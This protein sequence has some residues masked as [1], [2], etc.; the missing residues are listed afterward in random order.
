MK[1]RIVIVD[2]HKIVIEGLRTIIEREP[3]LE[4]VGEAVTGARGMRLIARHQPDVALVDIRLGDVSGLEVCRAAR[5]SSP[6][7]RVIILTGYI[8]GDLIHQ[9][10]QAGAVGYLL[11]DAESMDLVAKIRQVLRGE[12]AFD[13]RVTHNL[14]NYAIEHPPSESDPLLSAREVE[15]LRLMAQGMTNAEIAEAL[16]LSPATIK[17]YVRNIMTKLEARNRVDAVTRAVRKGLI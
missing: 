17:D 11:K 9:A 7:T 3:D 16:Y 13:P 10:L 8:N 2:D 4:I 1:H 12:L 15:V 6:N 14:A 5:Q